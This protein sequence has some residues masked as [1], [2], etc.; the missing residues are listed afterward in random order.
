MPIDV[1][2][3]IFDTIIALASDV[4]V[5]ES[6]V[7]FAASD[8]VVAAAKAAGVDVRKNT[9]LGNYK[10]WVSLKGKSRLSAAPF[11]MKS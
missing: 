7:W 6:I 4:K 5:T 9:A 11:Y 1:P 10:Y 8:D 3:L 2:A